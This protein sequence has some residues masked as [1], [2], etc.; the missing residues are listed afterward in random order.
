MKLYS[1]RTQY[2]FGTALI[3]AASFAL[4]SVLAVTLM[5]QAQFDA[6]KA[7]LT[8]AGRQAQE[9]LTSLN[10]RIASYSEIVRAAPFLSQAVVS[11]D[12]KK[13]EDFA[14]GELK[15]LKA[16]DPVVSTFEMTDAKGVVIMRGHNPGVLGDD[17]S[18]LAEIAAAL[19]G[20]TTLGLTVSPTS[21]QAAV[22]VVAPIMAGGAV[23]GTLKMGAY[24]TVRLAEEVKRRTGAEIVTIFRGKVTASTLPKD[25]DFSIE[26]GLL[27]AA[28]QGA[29]EPREAVVGGV[30]YLAELRHA[31]S[32]AGE[33]IVVATL[34][35]SA[36][37]TRK[38]DDFLWH[39]VT[40]GLGAL[41]VALLLGF[42]VGH[43]FGRPLTQTA[44]A[45]TK[46]MG[47][48]AA[49]LSSYE[50]DR[51]EI[52]DMARSL[53]GLSL[54]VV[55]SFRLRQTVDGMP[56]GVMT[57]NRADDWRVDYVNPALPRLLGTAADGSLIGASAQTA[58][59][60][61]GIDPALLEALPAD[62]LRRS[63]ERG[64]R[65]F[66][67][68]LGNIL[69][70]DG[71]KVGALVAW[72]DVSARKALAVRFEEAVKN[73][74]EVAQASSSALR[75]HA[76][77]VRKL[78]GA[79]QF[80]AEVVARSSEESSVSVNSVAATVEELAASVNAIAG[81]VND[82]TSLA[83]EAAQQSTRMVGVVRELQLASGRISEVVQLIGGIASQ[84]N[85]LALN[86]T[87]EAARAGGAGRGFAVVASEVKA[88]AGQTAKAAE[89]V[90]AQVVGIQARTA[91]AVAAIDAIDVIIARV[92]DVSTSLA[93]VVQQQ[94]LATDEIAGNTGLTAAGTQEV[95]A[96]MTQ[97]SASSRD[98]ETAAQG[99]LGQADELQRTIATLNGEVDR[100]LE[101]LAA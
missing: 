63:F 16:A 75:E 97:V 41:P 83:D 40:Y 8:S 88:L 57:L 53:K 1:L 52:G 14:V 25:A 58:L 84:T 64:S 81:Q 32:L 24:A 28:V 6:Q 2:A 34:V 92:A 4:A 18:K 86:A 73:V 17:K 90:V 71:G 66:T 91:D 26:P 10:A 13:L 59:A 65:S 99:M 93:A 69:A 74:V 3:F 11:G 51:S 46:L 23:V 87:I 27:T 21:G 36:P 77:D 79:T 49:N 38:A 70:P 80:Q 55:D 35:P 30:A 76:V 43:Y 85:L 60:G 56:I 37:Y 48:E 68:T 5:R 50:R 20:R 95:A 67:L 100:F 22:D 89:D 15:T 54:A 72:E 94:R 19:A 47:G 7:E 45:M 82:A 42:G 96:S 78:A 39:I 101:S 9:A 62:G 29:A 44:A 61:S 98:T 12:R 31:P 33:G